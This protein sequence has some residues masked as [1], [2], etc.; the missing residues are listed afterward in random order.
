MV[1]SWGGDQDKDGK[2]TTFLLEEYYL[3]IFPT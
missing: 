2:D 1:G 3:P